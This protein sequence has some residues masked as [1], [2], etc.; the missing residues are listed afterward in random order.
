[1]LI[2][3]IMVQKFKVIMLIMKIKVQMI[4]VMTKADMV[5]FLNWQMPAN[6]SAVF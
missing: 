6:K 4:S 2:M 3:K 5:Q 1:M